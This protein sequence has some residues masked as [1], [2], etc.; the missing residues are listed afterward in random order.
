MRRLAFHSLLLVVVTLASLSVPGLQPLFAQQPQETPAPSEQTLTPASVPGELIIR[1]KP[2]VTPEEIDAFYQEYGLTEM[3][4]LDPA[5]GGEER[6]LR[7]AFVPADVDQELIAMLERDPRVLYAE[8]NYI[9][10]VNQTT[11]NDPDFA[12]EWGLQNNGQ[13]GG[14]AGADISAVDGWKVTTGSSSVVVAI[15]D[16]GV[17]YTH[18]DLGPNMWVNPKECPGGYGNCVA[19]GVDDDNNG[20]E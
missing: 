17:D 3:D 12:K 15:I 20:Y 18:E 2:S 8:P 16:T 10:Q 6:A 1:F 13:T 9:V 4:D 5:P 11:P 14:T 7:L 19:D